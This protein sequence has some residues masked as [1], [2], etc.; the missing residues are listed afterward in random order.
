[1]ILSVEYFVE[2]VVLAGIAESSEFPLWNIN[3]LK[4]GSEAPAYFL[5]HV[6]A[7]EAFGEFETSVEVSAMVV[8]LITE[9]GIGHLGIGVVGHELEG[10][11]VTQLFD[12]LG[13]QFASVFTFGYE[14][15]RGPVQ[16]ALE[17]P[18]HILEV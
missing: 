14:H 1:M 15:H 11:L 3:K 2:V 17:F 13:L 12:H 18:C 16:L 7:L 10:Q 6:D 4:T 8:G 5:A 9:V